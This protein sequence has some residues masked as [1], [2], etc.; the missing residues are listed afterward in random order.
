MAFDFD[1]DEKQSGVIKRLLDEAIALTEDLDQKFT[2]TIER[3]LVERD[4]YRAR[5]E[6]AEGVVADVASYVGLTGRQHSAEVITVTIER[7]ASL[8]LQMMEDRDKA[9]EALF[10]ARRVIAEARDVRDAESDIENLPRRRA[11]PMKRLD[12]ALKYYD[13]Q[14]GI[15]EVKP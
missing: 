6:T 15:G 5:A 1:L 13:E 9:H 2:A 7:M 8:G 12:E 3:L 11:E 10:I 4:E 14:M